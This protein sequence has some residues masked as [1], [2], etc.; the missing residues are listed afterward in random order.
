M[1]VSL[2]CQN[3]CGRDCGQGPDGR[4]PR[5]A[6]RQKMMPENTFPPRASFA[7]AQVFPTCCKSC[8]PGLHSMT[9]NSGQVFGSVD[10]TC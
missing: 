5:R 2:V 1:A 7:G 3:G 8:V 4:V 9:R 6:S 10:R